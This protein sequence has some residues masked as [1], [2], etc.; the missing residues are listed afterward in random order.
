MDRLD[1]PPRLSIYSAKERRNFSFGELTD[2]LLEADMI[3]V[4]EKPRQ[5]AVPSRAIADHQGAVRQRCPARRRHGDVPAA[6]PGAARQI[7][8]RRNRRGRDAQGDGVRTRWGFHWSLYQPIADFCK[9]NACRWPRSMCRAEMTA[10]ISKAGYRQAER[11]GQ[12][13]ARLGRSSTSK[14]IAITGTR[15]LPRCTATQ[16]E[17]RAEGALVSS[18]DD[19]GRI[20]G[21]ERRIVSNVAAIYAAWSSWRAADTSTSAS[22]S[23]TARCTHRRQG[24]DRSRRAGRRCAKLFASPPADYVVI[25]R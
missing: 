20:H 17:R 25:V 21:S 14:R 12:E 16:G 6:V 10:K 23:R 11:R 5:R 9:R 2:R 13:D 19:L 1:G 8:A 3:C 22:A 15:R 18:D 4:G 24:G 7:H